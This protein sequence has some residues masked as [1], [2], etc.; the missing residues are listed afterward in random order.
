MTYFA[1]PTPHMLKSQNGL[2]AFWVKETF[3]QKA[4]VL[5]NSMNPDLWSGFIIHYPALFTIL[6]TPVSPSTR[7]I[8]PVLMNCVAT[9]VPVTDGTP[10]SLQTMAA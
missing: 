2:L 3:S 1:I 4:A 5:T 10:Y 8:S 9:P 7:T 6:T